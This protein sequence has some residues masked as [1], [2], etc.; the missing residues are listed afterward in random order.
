MSSYESDASLQQSREERRK[1][2]PRNP[3]RALRDEATLQS[4]LPML[5]VFP[6]VVTVSVS[7]RHTLDATQIVAILLPPFLVLA[8][9]M[10]I[11]LP[12]SNAMTWCE[13]FFIDLRDLLPRMMLAVWW[14]VLA[15]VPELLP[16]EA[17]I[18]QAV[19]MSAALYML[20]P[21]VLRLIEDF[22]RGRKLVAE[23]THPRQKLSLKA[24]LTAFELL[25][26][27]ADRVKGNEML[28][29]LDVADNAFSA[30]VARAVRTRLLDE[31]NMTRISMLHV[32][33]L[34]AGERSLMLSQTWIDDF[35]ATLLA[36]LIQDNTD[37]VHL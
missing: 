34:R 6:I 9:V 20:L 13:M 28:K 10:G 30:R 1:V 31:C 24:R 36:A 2:N 17:P 12:S 32:P 11:I 37:V 22:T 29:Q 19:F 35:H 26:I 18:Q 7:I 4:S 16:L 5:F 3:R 8:M 33:S 25:C 27:V 14:L 15:N 23:V 21:A